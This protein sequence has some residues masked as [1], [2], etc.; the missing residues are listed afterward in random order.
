MRPS[1][2]S[3]HCIGVKRYCPAVLSDVNCRAS[4][5]SVGDSTIEPHGSYTSDRLEQNASSSRSN[6]HHLPSSCL[7]PA[8]LG[9]PANNVLRQPCC[10]SDA[11]RRAGVPHALGKVEA[12]SASILGSLLAAGV[13][14]ATEAGRELK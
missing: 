11:K 4:Q 3:R 14:I 12:A 9:K 1:S 13:V 6:M 10:V 7:K 5:T 8:G 2:L